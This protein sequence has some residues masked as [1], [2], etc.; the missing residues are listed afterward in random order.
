MLK[1]FPGVAC[2]HSGMKDSQQFETEN[3][4]KTTISI[5][6]AA[7]RNSRT[8]LLL[9]AAV[10]ALLM[11]CVAGIGA[12]RPLLRSQ[13]NPARPL[14][15]GQFVADMRT[16]V[17]AVEFWID[18]RPDLLLDTYYPSYYPTNLALLPPIQ[19]WPSPAPAV[20]RSNQPD[21][22][23]DLGSNPYLRG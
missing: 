14:P 3:N 18:P 23:G 1:Q 6:R 2:S 4:M 17:A 7:T 19:S 20:C 9:G 15:Q 21:F 10:I 13:G 12:I 8:S 11:L 22:L 16:F 5:R